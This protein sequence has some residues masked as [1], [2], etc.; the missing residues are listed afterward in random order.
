RL[1][2]PANAVIDADMA[3]RPRPQVQ[4]NLPSPFRSHWYWL[5]KAPAGTD[6]VAA[7]SQRPRFSVFEAP[8]FSRATGRGEGGGG[9]GGGSGGGVEVTGGAVVG[10]GSV[11]VVGGGGGGGV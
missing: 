9:G 8:L 7:L 5:M 6:V 2:P 1:P 3:A 11:A 10:G 4:S